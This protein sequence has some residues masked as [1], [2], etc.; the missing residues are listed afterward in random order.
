MPRPVKFLVQ[1]HAQ[2]VIWAT[3]K[4]IN[5]PIFG[6]YVHTCIHERTHPCT[7]TCGCTRR[8]MEKHINSPIFGSS[9]LTLTLTLALALALAL[10]LTL[11]LAI[12]ERIWREMSISAPTSRCTWRSSGSQT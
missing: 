9:T 4:H 12:A 7:H 8:V 2:Y 6:T 5:S 10:A 3:E 1:L 11:A